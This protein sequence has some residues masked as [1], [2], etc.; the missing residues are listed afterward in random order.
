MDDFQ[1]DELI[2]CIPKWY[3]VISTQ[4]DFAKKLCGMNICNCLLKIL[5]VVV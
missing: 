4:G 1:M 5:Q 2:H 3:M